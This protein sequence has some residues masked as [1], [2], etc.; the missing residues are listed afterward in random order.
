MEDHV[1]R[2]LGCEEGEEPLRGIHM[3][4]QAH[5]QEMVV[6]VWYVFLLK[7]VRKMVTDEEERK[8]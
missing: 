4:L 2:E 7:T 6:K 1:K 5:I 3:S 8:T